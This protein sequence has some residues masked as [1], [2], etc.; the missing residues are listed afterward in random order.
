MSAVTTASA[1]ATNA[2]RQF[3][4]TCSLYEAIVSGSVTDKDL[5]EQRAEADNFSLTF[6]VSADAMPAHALNMHRNDCESDR[7]KPCSQSQSEAA[8]RLSMPDMR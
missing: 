7:S 3:L 5:N 2:I 8:P 6:T 4:F 1:E